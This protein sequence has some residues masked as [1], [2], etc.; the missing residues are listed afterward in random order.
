M[1][2]ILFSLIVP[3]YNVQD[4]LEKCIN[5]ILVQTYRNFEVVLIDDGS[6]DSTPVLCDRLALSDTRI[7]VYHKDNGGLSDARNYGIDRANGNYYVFVD[8]DDFISER[9]LEYFAP[10]LLKSHPEVL[11]TRLTE[12]YSESDIVEQDMEMSNYFSNGV[13]TEKALSWEMKKSKSAWPAPKKILSSRFVKK[14]NLRFLK[15]FLH[16]DVDWSSRVMM[17]AEKFAICTETWYY[18]RMK[19]EGSITNTISS[20][21][22]IDVIEMS[23]RLIDSVEMHSITDER[24]DII[25]ERIM[26]SV[27]PTLAFY[28][29]LSNKGKAQV[30]KCCKEHKE[31]LQ[32]APE[33]RHKMFV[34]VA[35]IF[36]FRIAL[37]LLIKVGGAV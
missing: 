8:S 1:D 33:K 23:E 16:E 2:E 6:T 32:R 7:R 19:R 37:N 5:S 11:L 26:R 3:C 13:T 30:V 17:H 21:R 4:Y 12:Y 35:N 20:K 14:N 10:I 22:I 9:T 15:G 29:K 34:N 18:H 24:R 28:G 31:L 25:S 36:G 27:Y